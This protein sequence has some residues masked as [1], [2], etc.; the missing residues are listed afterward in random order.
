M[1]LKPV[2]ILLDAASFGRLPG[3]DEIYAKV[4]KLGLPVYRVARGDNLAT[5]L[6]TGPG[7]LYF[8]V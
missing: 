8:K 4:K 7:N 5:K 1:G 3:S 6:S 2:L